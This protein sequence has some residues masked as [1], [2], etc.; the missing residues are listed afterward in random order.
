MSELAQLIE[1]GNKKRVVAS[2]LMNAHSSRSHALVIIRVEQDLPAGGGGGGGG[3][4]GGPKL[5][6][7]LISKVN[8][9]D[10]AGSER[11][12]KSGAKGETLQEAIAINQS[13]SALG[14]VI[15]AL[16]DPTTRRARRHTS[17]TAPPS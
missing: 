4:N 5:R 10:L 16:T 9:V 12:S 17:R 11:A 2:T 15:N 1:Q 3:G 14:N 6:R 13:L 8:L 7:K